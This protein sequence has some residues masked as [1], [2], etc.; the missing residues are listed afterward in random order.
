MN[1][2]ADLA[3]TP[4]YEAHLDLDA[5]MGEFAGYEMPIRYAGI[6][7]EHRAVRTAAGL[8]DVSHMGQI[9]LRGRE[10]ADAVHHAIVSDAKGLEV[11]RARYTVCCTE[12][13]GI[14][15]DLLVYRLAPDHFLLVVNAANV[16]KVF[17]WTTEREGHR[18]VRITDR[19]DEF[20]QIALQ[21][22]RAFEVLEDA[23]DVRR[24]RLSRFRFI[25]PAGPALLRDGEAIVSETGYT[26][27]SG[28][29]IYCTAEAARAIWDRLIDVGRPLSLR[30]AGL[31]ARDSLRLES[32]LTLYG[33]EIDEETH[34]YE[35][36]L[37]WLVAEEK[38]DFVGAEALARVRASG[39]D[40]QLRGFVL[41]E[42]GIPRQGYVLTNE[43]GSEVGVVTSGTQSPILDRGIGLGY[44]PRRDP[45]GTDGTPIGVRI[46]GRVLPA[47][48]ARP[49]LHEY[50]E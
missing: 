26:G 19:S 40:R 39:W 44:L 3:R 35:A 21:G 15:D 17:A 22:P 32:G 47:T 25:R 14:V 41:R 46:R 8:F 38:D 36:G 18:E 6:M 4:L 10:A 9:D 20:A 12:E 11:G 50:R 1:A 24:D 33:H 49:P 37:G 28:V 45:F 2:P 29:E 42:R 7:A 27:E 43:D 16:S 5:R 30:P 34:P 23:F 13:G 48:L 31:G